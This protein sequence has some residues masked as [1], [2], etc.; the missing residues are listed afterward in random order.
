MKQLARITLPAV[1]L[2]AA[3][4]GSAAAQNPVAGGGEGDRSAQWLYDSPL[5][6]VETITDLGGGL[7]EYSYQFENTDTN[8]LWHFGV[9]SNF[10][11]VTSTATWSTHPAWA[12]GQVQIDGVSPEYDGRNLD[13]NIR[14]L[15]NTWGPSFPN[16]TDPI[17]PGEVV[18]GFKYIASQ[19]D[20]S[21][22]YYF[23]ETVESGWAVNNGGFLAAVGQT[24]GPVPV[25]EV[26]W[27]RIKTEYAR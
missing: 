26:S 25:E 6:V 4:I 7:W 2:T 23:Y 17:N 13:A 1:L 16:T 18:D 3:F 24:C 21:P 22:K 14:Y 10:D 12:F 15:A 9:W 27:G 19:F 11:P 5:C 8:H 20:D